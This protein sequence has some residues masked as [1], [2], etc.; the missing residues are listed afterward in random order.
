MN[1]DLEQR[2]GICLFLCRL[3][4]AIV[5]LIWAYDKLVR[6]EHGVYMMD[7]YFF[8]SGVS[9]ASIQIFGVFEVIM[10]ILFLLGLFKRVTRGFFL[11]LSVV[12]V[13]V[14]EVLKGYYTALF[15]V[16]HPTILF[17]T[18]F[19]LLACTFGVYYLRDYDNKFTLNRTLRGS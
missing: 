18:G 8:T 15:I 19:C 3:S 2:L 5:F 1:K 16:A 14:P 13:S 4:A 9:E 7:T 12:A 10:C 11:F 6:P 17:F